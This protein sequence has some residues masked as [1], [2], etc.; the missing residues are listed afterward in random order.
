[1]ACDSTARTVMHRMTVPSL[2]L[3]H[4]GFMMFTLHPVSISNFTFLLF[5]STFTLNGLICCIDFS[6]SMLGNVG[7]SSS[8]CLSLSQPTLC[9]RSE[10]AHHSALCDFFFFL[11]GVCAF[12]VSVSASLGNV[13][14]VF[15]K[16]T[17]CF[18]NLAFGCA[19]LLS[20]TSVAFPLSCFPFSSLSLIALHFHTVMVALLAGLVL[21]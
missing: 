8:C 3:L 16:V 12:S 9:D 15:T 17:L 13:P 19:V 10:R 6:L 20:M 18:L 7:A 4:D 5:T 21:F 2:C 1:M 14:Y 11:S